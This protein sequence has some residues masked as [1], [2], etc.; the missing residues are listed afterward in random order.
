MRCG[1]L[2]ARN[3][4]N[5]SLLSFKG[6]FRGRGTQRRG[7]QSRTS[8]VY[9]PNFAHLFDFEGLLRSGRMP[10]STG[11]TIRGRVW[12]ESASPCY[13]EDRKRRPRRPVNVSRGKDDEQA[14]GSNPL[15]GRSLFDF[16]AFDPVMHPRRLGGSEPGCAVKSPP[17]SL[18]RS[19][20]TYR[21]PS[22]VR[23]VA[24]GACAL[25]AFVALS[26]S[27]LYSVGSN[28]TVEP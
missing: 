14:R 22:G 3:G 4:G 24:P 27:S 11:G 15:L 13:F 18:G 20:L 26:C 1:Y 21:A 9:D 17:A 2:A 6:Q 8:H 5:L 25:G 12:H 16:G 23:L 19:P 28:D 10:L 7:G